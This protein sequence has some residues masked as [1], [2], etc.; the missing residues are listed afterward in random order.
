MIKNYKDNTPIPKENEMIK[1]FINSLTEKQKI[2]YLD[3]KK[4]QEK[5]IFYV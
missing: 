2:E 4:Q 5:R 3:F 1:S